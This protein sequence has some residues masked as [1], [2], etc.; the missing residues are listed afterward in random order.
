MEKQVNN[1][2]TA[3]HEPGMAGRNERG[4][5]QSIERAFSIL[6]EIA[7]NREGVNLAELSKRI[8]LHNSTTFHLVKT[9]VSLGYVQQRKDSKKYRIG[10][11]LFTLAA[12]SL[13]ELELINLATP[14]LEELTRATGE[15]GHLAVRSG[16]DVVVIAKTSGAG[17]FQLADRVGVVRPAHCTALGKVLLAALPQPELERYFRTC[18]LRPFTAK[19]IV[20]AEPL[21]RQI[22]EVRRDGIAFDDGEFNAE[23]RCVAVPVYDLTSQVVAAIGISG[24]I[25][26]LSLQALQEK[27]RHVRSAAARLSQ[28]FGFNST[29]KSDAADGRSD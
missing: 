12:S 24:P 14:I 17:A 26:R 4:G 11:R 10:R 2:G 13:D 16:D 29:A 23:I 5:V 27:A 20:E 8:G 15:S 18:E 19:T 21:L 28:E 6:E 22:D 9:M 25:W 7:R 3:S 1:L